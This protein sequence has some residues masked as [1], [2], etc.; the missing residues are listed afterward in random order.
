MT[1]PSADDRRDGAS[2]D[3]RSDFPIDVDAARE[4]FA[5]TLDAIEGK[6]DVTRRWND[7]RSRIVARASEQP[8]PVVAVVIAGATVAVLSVVLIARAARR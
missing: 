3:A 2:A 4:E 1:T 6:F 5:A 8:V 7:L